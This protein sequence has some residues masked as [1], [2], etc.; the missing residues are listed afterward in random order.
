[1]ILAGDLLP[2]VINGNGGVGYGGCGGGD[3]SCI[4]L[5]FASHS[6]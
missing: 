5:F 1:M 3:D 6:S 2:S 4:I